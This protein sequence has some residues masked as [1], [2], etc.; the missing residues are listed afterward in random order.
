MSVFSHALLQNEGTKAAGRRKCYV[1]TAAQAAYLMDS[2]CQ[3]HH[4][5]KNFENF[6]VLRG[7]WEE[8]LVPSGPK[9][10]C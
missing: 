4:V 10:E 8:L 5:Q 7:Q 6:S 2:E 9:S 1:W 3:E